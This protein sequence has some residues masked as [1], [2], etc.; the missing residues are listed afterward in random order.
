ML[1]KLIPFFIVLT[2]LLHISS[3]HRLFP[4]T[5]LFSW[6]W[7]WMW[8]FVKTKI[9]LPS[10]SR[11][12]VRNPFLGQLFSKVLATKRLTKDE[13]MATASMSLF[14]TPS[15]VDLYLSNPRRYMEACMA[16]EKSGIVAQ[17]LVTDDHAFFKA[18]IKSEV[19]ERVLKNE[20]KAVLDIWKDVRVK[21]A[22][23]VIPGMQVNMFVNVY[24]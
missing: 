21:L 22:G 16:S 6:T 3:W 23:E 19:A 9:T 13:V 4:I 7:S 20:V 8:S 18:F 10:L 1:S 5:K 17:F 12:L 24:S 2:P 15:H 11:C 14:N